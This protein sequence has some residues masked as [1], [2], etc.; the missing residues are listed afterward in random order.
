LDYAP[1]LLIGDRLTARSTDYQRQNLAFVVEEQAFF[2]AVEK[3]SARDSF[4]WASATRKV[5][6]VME[7]RGVEPLFA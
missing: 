4:D 6:R 2:A 1:T 7:A 5:S 3:I